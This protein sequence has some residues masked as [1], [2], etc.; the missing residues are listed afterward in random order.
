M[1]SKPSSASRDCLGILA[2]L[3]VPDKPVWLPVV[4]QPEL[5]KTVARQDRAALYRG[6]ADM[7]SSGPLERDGIGM[8][9]AERARLLAIVGI[10]LDS[11]CRSGELAALR[12]VDVDADLE[13]SPGPLFVP[14]SVAVG[15][16]GVS[17]VR[18]V[19]GTCQPVEGHSTRRPEKVL[20][21]AVEIAVRFVTWSA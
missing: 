12:L 11:G 13:I 6:L 19:C 7:A 20:G 9:G 3:V 5:K 10:V 1:T 16:G 21:P 17:P 2:G 18:A 8:S 4:E 15:N 14:Q